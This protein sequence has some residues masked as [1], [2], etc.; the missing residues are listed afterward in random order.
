MRITL[1][2]LW[3][4]GLVC[5]A[6]AAFA[7]SAAGVPVPAATQPA[8]TEAPPP[9]A[10]AASEPAVDANACVPSCRAGF[11]CHAG[12]CLSRCNPVC[13]AGERCTA[14][15]ECERLPAAPPALAA[16]V[17]VAPAA[18]PELAGKAR[19]AALQAAGTWVFGARAGLLVYGWGT[20]TTRAT[21]SELS[22]PSS[23][24]QDVTDR[25]YPSVELEALIHA[26]PGLRAGA[27]YSIAPYSAQKADGDSMTHFGHE[28]ALRG[29][30]EGLLSVT[31]TLAIALRGQ[32][33]V[34]MLVPG[35]DL[36]KSFDDFLNGCRATSDDHCEA[37]SGPFVGPTG[38]VMLG[39]VGGSHIRWRFDLQLEH[40]AYTYSH[41]KDVSPLSV[42]TTDNSLETT[43]LSV[44][45]GAEL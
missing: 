8:P 1:W 35:G 18:A 5:T 34:R 29:I 22:R 33:G 26:S 16:P 37:D 2:G 23:A 27:G 32:A 28:Q 40:L 44:L 7:Q 21:R 43:R 6:Q 13:A 20:V 24:Q 10:P 4:L 11:V 45:A 42:R 41:V 9:A 3:G 30:V 38:G 19:A 15:G 14:A 39:L 36:K 17:P 12:Q 31:P 25:S